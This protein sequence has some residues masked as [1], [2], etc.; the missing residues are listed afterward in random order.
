VAAVSSAFFPIFDINPTLGRTFAP[1]EDR[2]GD[3][4]VVVLSHGLWQRVFA[5]EPEVLGRTLALSGRTVTVIG[6][7]PPEFDFPGRQVDLWRPLA[8]DPAEPDIRERHRLSAIGRLR[9]GVSLEQATADVNQIALQLQEEYPDVYAED[10]GFGAY[11]IP[12]H[13]SIVG[14][15]R[16]AL[17]VLLGAVGLVLLI[18][19][20]NV[21]NLLLART[22]V[23]EKELVVRLAHGASR[24]RVIRQLITESTLLA[25]MG[26]AAGLLIAVWGISGL[27][28]FSPADLV[29]TQSI[30]L[31]RHV[32]AFTLGLS[33]LTGVLS[34]LVPG[35]LAS[36][37]VA[38][39]ALKEGGR[40][41]LGP[42]RS[43]S[44]SALVICEVA[45]SLILL[46]AAG[47]LVRSFLH[48]LRVD[49]G[50]E[51]ESVLTFQLSLPQEG[52]PED[53]DVRSFYDE[54]YARIGALPGVDAAGGAQV[55][56]LGP[57]EAHTTILIK[58]RP[59]RIPG[60][61][62]PHA[63]LT[64]D[65]NCV[66]AGYFRV[67]GL[68]LVE[69]RLFDMRDYAESPPV[70][71]IDEAFAAD[72]WPDE[73]SPIGKQIAIPL[74]PNEELTWHTVV[75]LVRHVRHYGLDVEGREQVYVPYTQFH[76]RF[77]SSAK[78]VAVRS[79]ADPQ[80]LLDSIRRT[81]TSLDPGIPLYGVRTMD[82]RLADSLGQRRFVLLLLVLFA[83]IAVILAAVG[84]YAV[85]DYS[86]TQ[87]TQEIGVR[88][89]MGARPKDIL[90]LALRQGLVLILVGAGIGLLG[91]LGVMRL[92]AS[93]VFGITTTD[94][95]TYAVVTVLLTGVGLLATYIPARRA[96]RVNPLLATRCD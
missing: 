33:L 85:I 83:A 22:T 26:G 62:Y 37:S 35:L 57:D 36:R 39:E 70:A 55:L 87:R 47:L 19:C 31:D 60:P 77:V 50:Y 46:I 61:G 81:V 48:V 8:L 11:V 38:S 71:V 23:R 52:Y 96:A 20:G 7:M 73:A 29:R 63:G 2:P 88:M 41:S 74:G 69:G 40:S 95:G 90:K 6:I 28:A 84:L 16:P 78:Y 17:M 3:D 51:T 94:P 72:V 89:A 45:L 67:L 54:L 56:P 93:L 91:A 64:A 15:L 24:G 68:T 27:V 65:F 80:A 82:E 79:A 1:E 4:G 14:D 86:V 18:A 44:R 30:Q 66:S 53:K 92:L 5:G 25:L 34:G 9:S 49:P 12:L 43:R 10:M 76:P 58:D 21:A 32:L 42:R 59:R 75:G 13:E